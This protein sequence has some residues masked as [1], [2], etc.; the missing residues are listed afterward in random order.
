VIVIYD[1]KDVKRKMDEVAIKIKE[2]RLKNNLS[3]EK[4]AKSLGFSKSYIADIE[5]GRTNVSRNLLEAVLK[6]YGTS[7]DWL[8]TRN[9]ILFFLNTARAGLFFVYGFTQREIDR[10]EASIIQ[11]FKDK[12]YMLIDALGMKSANQLLRAILNKSGWTGRLFKELNQRFLTSEL[13]MIIKNLSRS[14][15]PQSG[16][17]IGSIFKS[18]FDSKRIYSEK[19]NISDKN[20][21][22]LSAVIIL[23]YASFLEKNINFL[24]LVMPI[25]ED[26]IQTS[27]K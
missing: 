23:D 1:Q 8:L 20:K 21:I 5:T 19:L 7:A 10:C 2:I 17:L 18:A 14:K 25:R 22:P 6:Q 15:I 11:L 13:I 9:K 16:F 12:D 24:D 26:D 4:F 27:L 3:Q